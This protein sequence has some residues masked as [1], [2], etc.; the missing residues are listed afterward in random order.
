MGLILQKDRPLT[1]AVTYPWL[2]LMIYDLSVMMLKSLK[3]S[4]TIAVTLM[5]LYGILQ[6]K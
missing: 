1:Q 6:K 3:L 5:L 2:K 4:L